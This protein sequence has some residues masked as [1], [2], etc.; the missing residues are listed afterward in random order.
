MSNGHQRG[1]IR[2]VIFYSFLF[3]SALSA[4]EF[5]FDPFILS[6]NV[7]FKKD[8]SAS[9]QDQISSVIPGTTFSYHHSQF[10]YS[11]KGAYRFDFFD[12]RRDLFYQQD[13]SVNL[14]TEDGTH[15][16]SA[17]FIREQ[18][19][20]LEL[21]QTIDLYNDII[22]DSVNPEIQRRGTPMV[23]YRMVK[24]SWSFDFITLPYFIAPYYPKNSSRFGIG[25]EF[26]HELAVTGNNET[27]KE[28]WQ[29]M[30]GGARVG[31]ESETWDLSVGYTHLI[32]RSMSLLALDSSFNLDR[33][34]FPVDFYYLYGQKMVGN[35][36]LKMNAFYKDFKD[37]SIDTI[38]LLT[39]QNESRTVQDH[40][41]I[42]LGL[43]GKVNVIEGHD[44]TWLIEAQRF[45]GLGL[46]ERRRYSVFSEDVSYA[47]RHGFND[48]KGQTIQFA[49]YIDLAY[50][51]DQ[52][53]Q[54][55]YTRLLTEKLKWQI[56]L[57]WIEAYRRADNRLNLDNLVGLNLI[58]DSDCIF[59]NFNYFF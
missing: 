29:V 24:D 37:Y 59:T 49:H 44:T 56:G 14:S 30:Q 12:Q 48:L 43:E 28:S 15:Q 31:Y 6:E 40:S 18:I 10:N 55:D 45:M 57:R 23:K 32:D 33:Y 42:S 2:G 8:D 1:R 41:A 53:F 22:M 35:Y 50:F 47:F 19:G 21:F 58:D 25:I 7:A 4:H 3:S 51:K 9:T 34:F 54:L 36:L 27:S 5:K 52:I 13:N 26:D 39:N 20:R 11:F 17:G 38:N 16:I 46:K